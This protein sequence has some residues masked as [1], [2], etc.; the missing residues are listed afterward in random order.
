MII[1]DPL[2]NG[3]DCVKTLVKNSV[4]LIVD[5]YKYIIVKPSRPRNVFPH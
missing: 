2:A 5:K 3:Q 4:V 1:K